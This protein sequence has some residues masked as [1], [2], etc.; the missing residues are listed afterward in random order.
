M[1]NSAFGCFGCQPV[2]A[3]SDPTFSHFKDTLQRLTYTVDDIHP[4]DIPYYRKSYVFGMQAH[5]GIISSTVGGP[6]STYVGI[7]C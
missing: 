1:I 6:L 4:A 3:K 5:S 7:L 2:L